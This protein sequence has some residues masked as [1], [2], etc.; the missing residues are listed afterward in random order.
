MKGHIIKRG[1][2]YSFVLDIGPHPETGIEDRDG[3]LGIKQKEAQADLAKNRR[4]RRRL[5]Y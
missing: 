3:F 5:I 1:S 2:K 4:N